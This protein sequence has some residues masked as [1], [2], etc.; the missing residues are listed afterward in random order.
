MF[1]LATCRQTIVVASGAEPPV[2]FSPDGQWLAFGDGQLVPAAGGA[3]TQPFGSSVQTWEW[4]AAGEV[5]G[6]VTEA[7]GV[8]FTTPGGEPQPLLPDGS[9]VRHLV[10]AADGSRLAV[11]RAGAGIQVVDVNSG[12]AL[13]VFHQPD[14]A[15]TPE[16]AGWSPDAQW[17]LYWRGP[18]GK[19]A[20]PLDAAPTDGGPWVN[21]SDPM[22]PYTDLISTCGDFVALSVGPGQ[23]MS[24]GK[25]ILLTGA[26]EWSF[27]NLTH[28]YTRSWFWPACSTDGRWVAVVATPNRA[29][30]SNSTAPRAL[31][32]L[33][34]DGSSRTRVIPGGE[35]APEFPRWSRDGQA[36]LVILRSG[37]EW[38][39]PG[40]LFLVQIE[41]SSGKIVS[42]MG[43]IGDLGSA[44]G[45]GGRQGWA[46][47]TDWYQPA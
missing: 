44:P 9:G 2:R 10:F 47:V 28:D 37:T 26:P 22:P 6:G 3:V 20:R 40:S 32:V 21:L 43:P 16:V 36:I 42:T 5:L 17:V 12:Q 19:E 29:E 24:E 39:S 27:H 35:D 45:E 4:S 14:P 46:A 13:T 8:V 33:A 15:L 1:D 7:G 30:S 25:Q 34:S 18:V 23:G 11:D 41:P 38:S 31:W